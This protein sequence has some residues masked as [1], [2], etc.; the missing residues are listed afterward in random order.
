LNSPSVGGTHA[1][2]NQYRPPD[3]V[4]TMAAFEAFHASKTI[5]GKNVTAE[6]RLGRGLRSLWL[7][8]IVRGIRQ[9]QI[10]GSD[11]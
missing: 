2:T 6:T 7:S 3:F 8:L 1:F 5:T 9:Q 4:T 11:T 10:S